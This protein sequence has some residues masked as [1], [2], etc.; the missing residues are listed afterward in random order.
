MPWRAHVLPYLPAPLGLAVRALDMRQS[1]ALREIRL[2]ADRPV[3]WVLPPGEPDAPELAWIPDHAEIQQM[4]QGFLEHSAYAH[5]EDVRQGYLTLRGGHRVGLCGR[6]VMERSALT[7]L[8]DI[9]SLCVRIARAVP[10]AADRLMPLL[11]PANQVP[12]ST[13]IF[14]APGLGKTTLL[15]DAVRQLS[16]GY[17]RRVGVVDERSEIAGCAH[18]QA[19]LEVG[20][21]TDVL[22]ACPK[23]VGMMMLLRAMCPQWL[24]VDEIGRAEDAD[25]LLEAAQCG[26]PVLATAHAGALDT[27]LERPMMQRLLESRVFAQ[28]VQLGAGGKIIALWDERG[29]LMPHE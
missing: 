19:Q 3:E 7:G 27:L 1:E 8:L 14:S 6:A 10:G 21:R 28:F 18:G 29:R 24:A 12:R 2:R 25:A 26:V 20:K 11:T 16:D 9:S 13:L 4:A 15:R 5:Q 22:D 23:A 17:G